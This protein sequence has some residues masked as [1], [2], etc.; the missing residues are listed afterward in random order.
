MNNVRAVVR[1]WKQYWGE[2]KHKRNEEGLTLIELMVVVVIL[3]IIAAIAIPSI[4]GA[5]NN[6]K[7]NT[8]ETDLSTLQE[9]LQRFYVNTGV[10]PS[11]TSNIVTTLSSTAD[12]GPYLDMSTINDGWGN[13]IGYESVGSSTGS[14]NGATVTGATGYIIASPGNSSMGAGAFTGNVITTGTNL[15]QNAI[16]A[17]GGTGFTNIK[18]TTPVV[19]STSI[20]TP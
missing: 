19:I 6:A 17:A 3:G 2:L 1:S 15:L 11:S 13:P 4:S 16:Y 5:M 12:G 8:T 9:A 7:I 14:F 18:E 10:Y 20:T